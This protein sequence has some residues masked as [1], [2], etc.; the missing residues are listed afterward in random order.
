V[1]T[2]NRTAPT[3]LESEPFMTSNLIVASGVVKEAPPAG[4]VQADGPASASESVAP[5]VEEEETL[6]EGRYSSK[7]FLGRAIL[8]AALVVVWVVLAIATWGF[9]RDG[10]TFLTEISG[11]GIVLY[12]LFLGWK[13]FRARRTHFYKLTTRRLFLTTGVF[14]RRVDQ[15]ELVRVK[16]L[17]VRESLIGT[18]L[19]IGTVI[20]ISSEPTFPKAH[21]LGI[22]DPRRVLDLIWRH[23]RQER[24]RRTTEVHPV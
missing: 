5:K 13:F 23:T 11:V 6:W 21:L 3:N 2:E 18:W 15:V 7:N 4:C 17:F 9:G 8:S 10:L 19:N 24:D 20:L 22:E 14:H 12:L 1:S 16:D